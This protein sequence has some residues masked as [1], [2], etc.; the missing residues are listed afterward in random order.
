MDLFERDA[1]INESKL[2]RLLPPRDW[3]AR[4]V[5]RRERRE[6]RA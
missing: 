1:D 6:Q 2:D 4:Q 3:A 5:A